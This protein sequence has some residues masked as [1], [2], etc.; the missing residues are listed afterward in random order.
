MADPLSTQALIEQVQRD[1]GD[2][3]QELCCRYQ[4]RILAAVRLRLGARLRRKLE[5]CDI[6][7][8]VMIDALRKVKSFDYKTEGAFLHYLN[9]VVENKIRDHADRLNAQMRN[10]DREVPLEGMRSSDSGCPL[11]PLE[12]HAAP[13]PSQIVS[14]RE[15][16]TLLERAMDCLSEEYRD[17]IIA[18]KLEGR[19]Y[20]E[21]AAELE[22]SVDAVRMRVK[23][24]VLAL[25]RIFTGLLG[26]H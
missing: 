14:L 24:A 15:N 11:I 13:T 12:D 20:A 18:V 17:L 7:Q 22:I 8:D 19:T 10:P 26:G 4:G 3:L 25:T 2:A 23:R 6:V 16:L 9:R 1:D 21:I 5:S